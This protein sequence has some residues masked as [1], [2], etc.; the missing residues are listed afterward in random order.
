MDPANFLE[1][2]NKRE[3]LNGYLELGSGDFGY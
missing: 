1:V 3:L 2:V